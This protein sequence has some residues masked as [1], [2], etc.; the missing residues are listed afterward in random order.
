MFRE[1]RRRQGQASREDAIA[2]LE[3]GKTGTLAVVG[4]EGY[5]Y[6]IPVNYVY[7]DGKI[8]FHSAASGHKIDAIKGEP[9]VSFSVVTKDEVL[10]ADFDTDFACAVAFGKARVVEEKEIREIMMKIA[11]KYSKGHEEGAKKYIESAMGDFCVVEI[12]V[13]H[14][15]GKVMSD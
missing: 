2:I 15:T 1:M 4:D 7:N 6:S 9:R 13:E 3:S 10:P 5:P 12:S 11:G 14:F 8:Y